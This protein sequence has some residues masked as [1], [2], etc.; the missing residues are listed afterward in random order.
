MQVAGDYF[1]FGGPLIHKMAMRPLHIGHF[2]QEYEKAFYRDRLF[3]ADLVDLIQKHVQGFLYS[4][5]ITSLDDINI[6]VLLEFGEL[7]QWVKWIIT[8]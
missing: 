5:N 2:G 6:V 3:R 1:G 7:Q 8:P 4:C